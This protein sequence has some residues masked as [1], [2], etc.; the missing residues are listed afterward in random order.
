MKSIPAPTERYSRSKIYPKKLSSTSPTKVH[1][2]SLTIEAAGVAR[3]DHGDGGITSASNPENRQRQFWRSQADAILSRSPQRNG[4]MSRVSSLNSLGSPSNKS[5]Q[6]RMTMQS[7]KSNTS[8]RTTDTRQTMVGSVK[9]GQARELLNLGKKVRRDETPPPSA[10]PPNPTP[11]HRTKRPSTP[12]S[13]RRPAPETRQNANGSILTVTT[14]AP[15]SPSLAG[16]R[17]S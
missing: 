12:S 4:G 15:L 3:I 10:L 6:T 5:V 14:A 1:L 17:S 16:P 8:L 7:S 11:R 2:P 9:S 13:K